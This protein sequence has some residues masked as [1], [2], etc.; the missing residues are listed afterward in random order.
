MNKKYA[1]TKAEIKELLAGYTTPEKLMALSQ[2]QEMIAK[3]QIKLGSQT[4]AGD[5]ASALNKM[6]LSVVQAALAHEH[7][8]LAVDQVLALEHAKPAAKQQADKS[9]EDYFANLFQV[10]GALAVVYLVVVAFGRK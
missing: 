1:D 7:T 6:V 5:Q 4:V 10:T 3:E 8:K 9:I 2:L